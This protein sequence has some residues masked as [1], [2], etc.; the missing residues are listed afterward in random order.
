MN[1]SIASGF[2]QSLTGEEESCMV[3]DGGEVDI[4]YRPFMQQ[5]VLFFIGFLGI[6]WVWFVAASRYQIQNFRATTWVIFIGFFRDS[7]S[8]VCGGEAT[9]LSTSRNNILLV[10][11]PFHWCVYHRQRVCEANGMGKERGE[12]YCSRLTPE[13]C[14]KCVCV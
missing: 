9:A 13:L 12:H 10:L 8:S 14:S 3:L 11:S 6:L 2:I 1:A 4:R 7:S 5:H